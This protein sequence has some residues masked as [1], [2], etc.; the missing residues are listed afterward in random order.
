[1]T[2]PSRR[3]CRGPQDAAQRVVFPPLD[4]PRP[5]HRPG[6]RVA[7]AGAGRAR[8]RRWCA[9]RAAGDAKRQVESVSSRRLTT[10][11]DS[12]PPCATRRA[13]RHRG[14]SAIADARRRRGPESPRDQLACA[15][16]AARRSPTGLRPEARYCAKH[17][18]AGPASRARLALAR[19]GQA[20]RQH[21]G[22][23]EV[24]RDVSRDASLAPHHGFSRQR[25]ARPASGS[26]RT[27]RATSFPGSTQAG[28]PTRCHAE[29]ELDLPSAARRDSSPPPRQ[30]STTTEPPTP[31]CFE[32]TRRHVARHVALVGPLAG[33]PNFDA[34]QLFDRA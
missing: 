1:V 15:A 27:S 22:R 13:T 31:R 33:R 8:R 30:Q 5:G 9:S 20:A 24:T 7:G 19:R 16:A 18:P 14:L 4:K 25:C 17:L 23:G 10:P 2:D 26:C 12:P 32:P 3:P 28:T 21:A 6:R 34:I 11:R 29:I